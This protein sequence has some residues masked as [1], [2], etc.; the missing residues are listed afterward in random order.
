MICLRCKVD[1]ASEGYIQDSIPLCHICY[2]I[3]SAPPEWEEAVAVSLATKYKYQETHC[4]KC[5]MP[6]VIKSN[7]YLE[8]NS[9]CT[10]CAYDKLMMIP[11]VG[12]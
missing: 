6:I 7:D 9:Y 2:E 11:K 4:A 1:M 12:E 3:E 8:D 10:T 5:D